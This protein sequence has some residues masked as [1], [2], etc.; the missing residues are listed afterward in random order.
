MPAKHD[1]GL[2]PFAAMKVKIPTIGMR[3]VKTAVAVT[4][5]YLIFASVGLIY[6][7]DLGGILG[8]LGPLYTCITC[9]VCMQSSLG[10]SVRHGISRFLGVAIGSA[11]G[12]VALAFDQTVLSHP[13]I[14]ALTLGVTLTIA[15]WLCMLI[16]RPAACSMACVLPCIILINE[17]VGIERYYY[18]AARIIETVL[19]VAVAVGINALLPDHRP[20][21]PGEQENQPPKP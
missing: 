13:L 1:A 4:I 12:V 2:P 9:V 15:I 8:K 18:A 16:D 5:S 3:T 7:D 21:E 17:M 11:L 19:G 10:Q 6:R 20:P 14:T